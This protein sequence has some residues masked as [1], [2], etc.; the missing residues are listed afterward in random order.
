MATAAAIAAL[1]GGGVAAGSRNW[2]AAL[3]GYEEVPAQSTSAGGG[4]TAVISQDETAVDWELSYEATGVTQS[5]LHF[6]QA[7]V[8]GGISVFLCS[9]L[10]N[11]PAGTQ[12]CPANGGTLSHHH[13]MG[14]DHK[15]WARAEVPAPFRA[16]I[17]AAKRE[18]DPLGLMNPGLW[19]DD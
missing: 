15:L 9:N 3:N 11:G 4:F 12:P 10:G 6:G 14:R 19:F 7:G 8:N 18:L 2:S 5:H 17:R 13:A 1:V 16:A